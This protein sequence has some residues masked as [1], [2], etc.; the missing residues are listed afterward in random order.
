MDILVHSYEK[1]SMY[2]IQLKYTEKQYS[3][4]EIG[5]FYTTKSQ[6]NSY[7]KVKSM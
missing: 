2:K 7:L 5:T 3:R 4:Y 1:I 6:D